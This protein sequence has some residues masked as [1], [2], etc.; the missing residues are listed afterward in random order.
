MF[1][2]HVYLIDAHYTWW[3][4]GKSYLCRIIDMI[5]MGLAD[6]VLFGKEVVD[7]W[8]VLVKETLNYFK[9]NFIDM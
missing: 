9:D 5:N 2:K 6:E 4:Q 3:I 1:V 7:R 8:P